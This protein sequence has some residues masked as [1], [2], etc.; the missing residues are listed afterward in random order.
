M[1]PLM[2]QAV[3]S[4][5]RTPVLSIAVVLTLALGIGATSAI[6][7]VVNASWLRSLPYPHSERV[8]A[9]R[10]V[11]EHGGQNELFSDPNFDDV[12]A[13]NTTLSAVAEY[14]SWTTTVSYREAARRATVAMVSRDFFATL[15]LQPSI[16]R[17]F[18]SDEL[19]VNAAPVVLVSHAYWK[20][21]LGGPKQI[22][23]QRLRFDNKEYAIVG[24]MPESLD[25]PAESALWIPREQIEPSWERTA[26]NWF[27]IGRLKAGVSLRQA[28]LDV[29]RV[30]KA[31]KA[32]YG[33]D[34]WMSDAAVIPLRE[35]LV[36]NQK[37]TLLFLLGAALILLLAACANTANLLL[38]KAAARQREFA[39]RVALGAGRQQ[40]LVQFFAEV[41]LLAACGSAFG[42]LLA[43]GGVNTLLR[44][45]HGRLLG[46]ASIPL[47]APAL[48]VSI[49]AAALVAVGLSVLLATRSYRRGLFDSLK[50]GEHR[51]TGGVRDGRLRTALTMA[52][53]AIATLLLATAGLMT[54]SLARLMDVQPGFRGQN[55][56]IANVS[57]GPNDS[58]D[59]YRHKPQAEAERIRRARLIEQIVRQVQ[60]IPGVDSVGI[61]KDHPLSGTLSNGSFFV[62]NGSESFQ[63]TQGFEQITESMRRNPD[64]TGFAWYQA[65][66]GGYFTA[67]GIPLKR[68]RLFDERDT[69]DAP[70]VALISETLAR[71]RWPGQDPVGRT[72]EFGGMDGDL[73]PLTIVGVVGDVR[74]LSLESEPEPT[75]YV[76]A[77][78][79]AP[80]YFS[81]VLHTHYSPIAL[82][83]TVRET[84]RR[85][86]AN[87]VPELELLGAVESASFGER[88]FQLC[89]LGMFAGGALLLAIVGLYGVMSYSV[90]ERTR[91][92]GVRM[93]LGA[94]AIDVVGLVLRQ[95]T[96]AIVVGVALGMAANLCLTTVMRSL[97]FGISATDPL[98]LA[99]V[100]G[101]LAAVG[102]FACW[103]PARRATQVDPLV[104]LRQ[105]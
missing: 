13:G 83:P 54:R 49:A 48:A 95:G 87:A 97:L 37:T 33:A 43:Q 52:Q 86:D 55:V 75:I 62:L 69:L 63:G 27:V 51:Q 3:R 5:S 47:N 9:L 40:M 16:G 57:F 76:G 28:Q 18:T 32:R 67:L 45:A 82:M 66:T 26:H 68:G 103:L 59:V 80:T 56:L 60:A 85:L 72:I 102:A 84:L 92:F 53:I 81:V 100:C 42:V 65:A 10:Q 91:E 71:Q 14:S 50:Q 64:R 93:A 31:V 12:R 89:L 19:R 22:A 96:L 94:Q 15:G 11:N 6:C 1:Q 7:S 8:V 41:G 38:A 70:H 61:A 21:V 58:L 44:L 23:G 24:V 29:S 104:A 101:V 36:G 74:Q 30:A 77:A 105:D 46:V 73:R 20:S 25:F 4:L 2:Q 39:V 99:G 79:I 17:G 78:Q 90:S 34:T 88:R 35:A 98:T